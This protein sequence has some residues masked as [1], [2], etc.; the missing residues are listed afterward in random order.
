MDQSTSKG[1]TLTFTPRQGCRMVCQPIRKSHALKQ[2]ACPLHRNSTPLT[3]ARQQHV[4]DGVQVGQQ[5]VLL[6]NKPHRSGAE[7]LQIPAFQPVD[8]DF[9]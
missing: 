7:S 6:K 9:V 8:R 3:N 2:T 1:D 5:Q 4:V